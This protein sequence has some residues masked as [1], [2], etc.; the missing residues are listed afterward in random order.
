MY[1][2]TTTAARN[3]R[4]VLGEVVYRVY[5]IRNWVFH[6]GVAKESSLMRERVVTAT[7]ILARIFPAFVES[8][9][10]EDWPNGQWEGLPDSPDVYRD[11]TSHKDRP[12][13]REE[14]PIGNA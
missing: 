13:L 14:P 5:R 1:R 12:E 2:G 9:L 7:D 8:M 4:Q 6:G 11:H 3:T 10:A